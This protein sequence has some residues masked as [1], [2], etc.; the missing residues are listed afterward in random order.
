MDDESKL[1]AAID[2]YKAEIE[3]LQ[4]LNYDFDAE[5]TKCDSERRRLRAALITIKNCEAENDDQLILAMHRMAC[6]ALTV[7][8]Q[9]SVSKGTEA[10]GGKSRP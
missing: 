9:T 3:R 1:L 6:A 10:S 8:E 7:N 4:N 2:D 5:L